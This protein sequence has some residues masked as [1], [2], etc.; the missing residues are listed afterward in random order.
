MGGI[1]LRSALTASLLCLA[2]TPIACGDG[3]SG[4]K[5]AAS[6]N[7]SQTRKFDRF[8]LYWV[9]ASYGHLPLRGGT[10]DEVKR[11]AASISF[12]YGDCEAK[13]DTG[14]ALPIEVQNSRRCSRRPRVVGGAGATKPRRLEI[15]G[16]PAA[17]FHDDDGFDR[18]EVFFPHTTVVVYTEPRDER[19]AE[20][21]AR[22]LKRVN[23]GAGPGTACQ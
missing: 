21:I 14:C 2:A 4:E 17:A 19:L 9:G 5:A 22:A 7:L 8:P 1:R 18:I 20:R 15:R 3:A 12:L 11:H 13:G 16:R 10:E 23:P 6:T